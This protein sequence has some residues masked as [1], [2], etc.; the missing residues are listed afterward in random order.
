MVERVPYPTVSASSACE[1][2]RRFLHNLILSPM[3]SIK[4]SIQRNV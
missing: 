1:M 2:P 4:T 3:E